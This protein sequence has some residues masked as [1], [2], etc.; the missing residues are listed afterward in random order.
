VTESWIFRHGW[1]SAHDVLSL[2][3]TSPTR[4]LRKASGA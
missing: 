2:W 3:Q 1:C 4:A